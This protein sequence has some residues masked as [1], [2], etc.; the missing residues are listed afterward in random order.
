MKIIDYFFRIVTLIAFMILLYPIYFESQ[1][2]KENRS[3]E[4]N[5]QNL[6]K[7][8]YLRDAQKRLTNI[9]NSLES[10]DIY[11]GSLRYASFNKD[12]WVYFGARINIPKCIKY[13]E[14]EKIILDNGFTRD[15]KVKLRL[16]YVSREKQTIQNGYLIC[17]SLYFNYSYQQ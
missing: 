12:S 3:N 13:I 16:T 1:E 4:A 7:L 5:I 8:P 17:E 10:K 2:S 11:M 6:E 15:S 14:L 9:A